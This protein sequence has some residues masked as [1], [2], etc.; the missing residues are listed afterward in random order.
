MLIYL[1][2]PYAERQSAKQ[3][4]GRFDHCARK[5]YAPT[6]KETELIAKFGDA[7]A[8]KQSE[9]AMREL[10]RRLTGRRDEQPPSPGF[11]RGDLMYPGY[12]FLSD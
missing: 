6:G 11:T 1:E 3:L 2:V 5:W 10:S 9:I 12:A 7:T 4:G 8:K